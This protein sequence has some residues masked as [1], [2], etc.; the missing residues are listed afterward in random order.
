MTM[1]I[2]NPEILRAALGAD[3]CL[4]ALEA[5]HVENGDRM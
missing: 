3:A 5:L 2:A 4:P 1:T